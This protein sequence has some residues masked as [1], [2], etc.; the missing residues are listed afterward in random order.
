MELDNTI[1][2]DATAEGSYY[3]YSFLL[4]KYN[5]YSV[6]VHALCYRGWIVMKI[7]EKFDGMSSK[8]FEEIGNIRQ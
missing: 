2:L 6:R 1:F 4:L 8:I 3:T 5:S 7:N